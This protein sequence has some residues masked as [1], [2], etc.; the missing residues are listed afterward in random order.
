MTVSK[1]QR[2]ARPTNLDLQNQN[3]ELHDC[4]EA[5]ARKVETIETASEK[6]G[7]V[8]AQTAEDMSVTKVNVA[9]LAKA[10]GVTLVSHEDVIAGRLPAKM[11]RRRVGGLRPELAFA[12]LVV[13][14]VA[15]VPGGQLA[16]KILEPAAVAAA[17]ALH[18]ALLTAH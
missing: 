1:L 2:K 4:L 6:T 13:A 16:Y 17:A 3:F 10:M 9:L 5:T 18:H 15:A 8:V 14:I 11:G 7:T 12:G